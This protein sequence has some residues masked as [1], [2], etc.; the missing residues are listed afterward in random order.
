MAQA[1]QDG[2]RSLSQ[3]DTASVD[4]PNTAGQLALEIMHEIRNPL[5][6]LGHLS[7]LAHEEAA[8]PEQVRLYMRMAEEQ[9]RTLNRIASQTLSFAR[10]SQAR[11]QIDLVELAEAALRIHQRTITAKRIHLVK[12]VPTN[13]LAE[14]HS[15]QI[16]QVLSNLILNAIESLPEAGTLTLRMR[17]RR[18]AIDLIVADNGHGIAPEHFEKLFHPF[19]TTKRGAGNGIGLSLCKR[20]VED[21]RGRIGVRSSVRPGRNGSIFKITLPCA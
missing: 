16:L 14:A 15:G 5:E 11:G 18:G 19:F 17:K 20:I 6:A 2:D 13:L 9:I 21:H 3:E 1:Q 12:K 8:N 7:Y 4:T 10:V